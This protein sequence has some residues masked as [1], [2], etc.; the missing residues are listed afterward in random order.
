MS[1]ALP[2]I[3]FIGLG[4]MGAP[5]V[6]HLH[7]AGYPLKVYNRTRSKAEALRKDGIVVE[8]SPKE[9]ALGSEYVIMNV[10]DTP[11]VE[12]VLFS[13]G[14]GSTCSGESG[15]VFIDHSTIRADQ[16]RV[17]A[18]KLKVMGHDFL[19]APVSG[20]DVGAKTASLTIMVGGEQTIFENALPILSK[21]GKSITLVGKNG[22]GQVVKASNQILV[23][24]NLVAVCESL[25][26]AKHS[27]V[28]LDKMLDV[29]S[30]GAA[31]S[32]AL[33]KLGRSIVKED[34]NPGFM[35]KLILKDLAIVQDS[36]RELG[37]SLPGLSLAEQLFRSSSSLGGADLGTQAMISVYDQSN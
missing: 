11:D 8:D 29:V 24:I 34:L 35:T 7:A 30:S 2:Q 12:A 28:D 31:Q 36:A 16:T 33:E 18:E 22:A 27:G 5:M 17:F 15:K 9:A 25:T 23:A 32:W 14:T 3:G 1:Q 37:L 21:L 26:F 6:E 19:D 13:E 4:I 20:G 10:T